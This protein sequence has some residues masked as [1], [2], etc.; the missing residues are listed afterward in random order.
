M[1]EGVMAD[2]A[3]LKLLEIPVIEQTT[4]ASR[5]TRDEAPCAQQLLS[6]YLSLSHGER[7][8]RFG[9][10]MSDEAIHVWRCGL[11]PWYTKST[12][13]PHGRQPVGIVEIFGSPDEEWICPEMAIC[14]SERAGSSNPLHNL[15]AEGLVG[16]NRLGASYVRLYFNRSETSI[17]RLAALHGGELNRESGMAIVRCD[18]GTLAWVRE[19]EHQAEA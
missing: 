8:N 7:I 17:Q 4:T 14:V 5:S 6:F 10:A 16:A 2:G 19:P 13:W 3:A 11:N 15:F 1:K 12:L 18:P 9:C